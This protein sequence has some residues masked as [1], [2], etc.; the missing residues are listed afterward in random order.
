MADVSLANLANHLKIAS[1]KWTIK[2][3]DEVSGDG[4]GRIFAAELASPLWMAEVELADCEANQAKQIAARIRALHGPMN[5][6][7]LY[8]PVSRFPQEDSDGTILGASAVSISA[9]GSDRKAIS[10]SGLPSGYKLTIGDKVQITDASDATKIGFFEFSDNGVANGLGTL[11]SIPV[12]PHLPAWV[13]VGDIVALKMPA[14]RMI[15][16]PESH[17]PGTTDYRGITSGQSF[18][19]IQK[20]K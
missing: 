17:D 1:V 8:D 9:V 18:K 6:F 2:R 15:M 13:G 19:A 16:I 14:C 5:V 11:S 20:K 10:L 3:N 4:D 12:L 7:L